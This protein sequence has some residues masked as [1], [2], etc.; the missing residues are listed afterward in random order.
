MNWITPQVAIGNYLDATD[1][2]LLKQFRSALS[3]DP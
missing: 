3:L 2:E 1:R